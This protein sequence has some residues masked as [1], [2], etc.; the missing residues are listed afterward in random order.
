MQRLFLIISFI[1]LLTPSYGARKLSENATISILTCAPGE[2]LYSL[3]GHSAIRVKDVSNGIDHVF[4]YGTFDFNTPNFYLKFANG[5]LKY[6]LSDATFKRFMNSYFRDERSI[7]EQDLNLNQSEKQALFDAIIVNLQPEHRY[8]RYDFFFDNCATRIRDIVYRNIDGEIA[9]TD[10]TNQTLPFRYFIH[11][12]EKNK[13]WVKDGLDIILGRGTDNIANVYN[14][15]FLPDYLMIYFGKAVIRN[16]GV[17]D[18]NLIR[19]SRQLLNFEKGTSKSIF[20]TPLVV[21]WI[22]FG[23][24]L[25]LTTWEIKRHKKPVMTV[26]R[27]LFLAVGL[28]AILIVFLWF[29]TRHSVTGD[30]YNILW[31]NP[32]FILLALLPKKLFRTKALR[33]IIGIIIIGILLFTIGWVFIP[34]HIPAMIF[35]L[36]LLLLVRLTSLYYYI[37]K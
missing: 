26:N 12:Y 4:N 14:Q 32:L 30:N 6:I 3:Y 36:V 16:E 34:Q 10:T 17:K 21:F 8:Y 23:A 37:N 24:G 5:N 11:E 20:L 19:E 13:P 25:V 22:L 28:V 33:I 35:P 1:L 7:W 15:M 27:I 29:F 18:R 2:E 31:S 9:Y